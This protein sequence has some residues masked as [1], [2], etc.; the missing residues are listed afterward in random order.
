MKNEERSKID[1]TVAEI[2]PMVILAMAIVWLII[3]R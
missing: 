2:I 3:R 1:I